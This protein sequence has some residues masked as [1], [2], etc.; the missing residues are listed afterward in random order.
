MKLQVKWW[1]QRIERRSLCALEKNEKRHS[2][3]YITWMRRNI[4]NGALRACSNIL[5][6][7]IRLEMFRIHTHARTH[8]HTHTHTHTCMDT[9][10]Q[11]SHVYTYLLILRHNSIQLLR[12]LRPGLYFGIQGNHYYFYKTGHFVGWYDDGGLHDHHVHGVC[13]RRQRQRLKQEHFNE[14]EHI[15]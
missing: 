13:S 11:T 10:M 15:S 4:W 14:P 5:C 1:R 6:Q 2:Q 8:A 12:T 7:A 9:H 3:I